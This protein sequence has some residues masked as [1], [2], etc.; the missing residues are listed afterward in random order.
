MLRRKRTQCYETITEEANSSL[1][2]NGHLTN[3]AKNRRLGATCEDAK[4][5]QGSPWFQGAYDLVEET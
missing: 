3:Q 4:M 5:P 1:A 2:G